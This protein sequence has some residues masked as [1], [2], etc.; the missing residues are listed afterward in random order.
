MSGSRGVISVEY[1]ELLD[2]GVQKYIFLDADGVTTSKHAK[3][4]KFCKINR[5]SLFTATL[6]LHL[7]MTILNV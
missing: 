4:T 1:S 3:I 6:C 2:G 5:M 7:G